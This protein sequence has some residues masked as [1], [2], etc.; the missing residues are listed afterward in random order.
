M[1]YT[2]RAALAVAFLCSGAGMARATLPTANAGADQTFAYSSLPAVVTLSGGGADPDGG[3]IVSYLWTT[4]YV[5]DGSAAALSSASA[6]NPTFTADEPGTYRFCLQVTDD[7]AET[8][9]TA[10]LDQPTAA[11]TNVMATTPMLGIV[12]PAK[13]QRNTWAYL[14]QWGMYLDM[15]AEAFDQFQSHVASST[16]GNEGAAIVGTDAK[17]NLGGGTT[18]EAVLEWLNT[19]YA[20]GSFLPLVGGTMTGAILFNADNTINLGSSVRAAA[21]MWARII[22]S[23]G[24]L[25]IAGS[26]A[27]SVTIGRAAIAT[28]IV[29]NLLHLTGATDLTGDLSITGS[30]FF[31]SDATW[32]VGGA[33]AAAAVVWTREV[34]SNGHMY[35]GVPVQS[36][37]S[38]YDVTIYAGT[39]ANAGGGSPGE[40]GGVLSCYAGQG[41]AAGASLAAGNGQAAGF[42]GGPGGNG[43][44]TNAGGAGGNTLIFGGLPGSD[45]G[46]GAG[47]GGSIYVGTDTDDGNVTIGNG[48]NG[49]SAASTVTLAASENILFG[50]DNSCAIGTP[51]R[52]SQV[53][54]TRIVENGSGTSLSIQSSAGATTVAGSDLR[55]GG[56]NGGVSDGASPGGVGGR[57]YL[58]SGDGG[59]GSGAQAAGDGNTIYVTPGRGGQGTASVLGGAGGDLILNAGPGG[60]TG[61]FGAGTDGAIN[62]GTSSSSSVRIGRSGIITTI[63][64]TAALPAAWSINGTT[65][66]ATAANLNTLVGGT[67]S[68]ADSLHRHAAPVPVAVDRGSVSATAGAGVAGP[69]AQWG[70]PPS[71][72]PSLT[73]LRC[74]GWCVS[75]TADD[76][77]CKLVWRDEAANLVTTV[78]IDAA[79]CG[80]SGT[81]I[82]ASQPFDASFAATALG[83]DTFGEVYVQ[84]TGSGDCKIGRLACWGY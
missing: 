80:V 9:G 76:A 63:N 25:T 49:I 11:C 77:N 56:G 18:V 54:Y 33:A 72:G 32:A 44:A 71:G 58:L 55:L 65:V 6:Q 5:P 24:A 52:A 37:T 62:I 19:S 74:T 46:A 34:A 75:S 15:L 78:T 17:T 27:S 67:S 61:G 82:V 29:A 79:G 83:A 45:G 43:S 7:D 59:D 70:I 31:G 22:D 23:T 13:G 81:T 20:T 60:L 40:L 48:A 4:V 66:N 2:M 1:T 84:A 51:I 42:R 36:S 16:S 14:N 53:V 10:F 50:A 64:G 73:T 12:L 57:A 3:S 38:G 69:V 8:N 39:G 47:T 68:N 30:V 41:G 21:Q 26:S 35:V 28:S